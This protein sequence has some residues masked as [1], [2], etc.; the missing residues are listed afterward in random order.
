MGRCFYFGERGQIFAT[1]KRLR[2]GAM[3]MRSDTM[4]DGTP[5]SEQEGNAR[6]LKLTT[7]ERALSG[8]QRDDETVL[9]WFTS[10]VLH[11]AWS[12]RCVV[13]MALLDK[14]RTGELRW[15]KANNPL[16]IVHTIARRYARKLYP[17]LIYGNDAE[18]VLWPDE[19]ALSTILRFRERQGNWGGDDEE[20]GMQD[21]LDAIVYGSDDDHEPEPFWTC[22][23]TSV[24]AKEDDC[25]DFDWHE[26]G[27]SLGLSADMS[28][29]L[30]ARARGI[31]RGEMGQYLGWS[32]QKV[33]RTWRAVHR[34]T[35]K[36]GDAQKLRAAFLDRE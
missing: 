2:W 11:F 13:V 32:P 21:F 6:E 24:L 18:K 35:G 15:R 29:L 5:P 12:W 19:R 8:I 36:P 1:L 26:I 31:T 16:A 25:L 10:D 27:R 3:T 22:P 17:E 28:T 30:D 34:H 7:C 33:Q 23:A 14:D 20:C 9:R 4:P